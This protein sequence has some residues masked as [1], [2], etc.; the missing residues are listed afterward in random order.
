M[1]FKI[2]EK[3]KDKVEVEMD[4]KDLGM[5]LV[6]ALLGNGVD[7]YGYEPHPLKKGFRVHVASD[8]APAQLKK[9]ASSLGS[10]WS[11]FKKAVEAKLK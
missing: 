4:D 6:G 3:K 1:E 7:A 10:D 2:V 11:E 9:A 5:A 8:D